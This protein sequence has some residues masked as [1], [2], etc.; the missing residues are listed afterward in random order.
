V[1]VARLNLHAAVGGRVFVG[2]GEMPVHLRAVHLRSVLCSFDRLGKE[3]AANY[4]A[5]ALLRSPLLLGSLD[6]LGKLSLR[7]QPLR[8]VHL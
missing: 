6:L 4:L 2:A 5:D 8:F 7:E 3:L 1:W